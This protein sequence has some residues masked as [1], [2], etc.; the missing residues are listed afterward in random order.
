M[1]IPA[2]IEASTGNNL[3]LVETSGG[4]FLVDLSHC[5]CCTNFEGILKAP[6]KIPVLMSQPSLVTLCLPTCHG[7]Q[8]TMSPLCSKRC[9]ML[10]S[11]FF[12]ILFFINWRSCRHCLQSVHISNKNGFLRL[13]TGY[14][15]QFLE[16]NLTRR[17]SPCLLKFRFSKKATK[18]DLIFH[19]DVQ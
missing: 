6:I 2:N 9:A 16:E 12:G 4:N 14:E 19:F 8:Q 3:L 15:I 18:F 11:T 13:Q 5:L 1:V 17:V 10:L 7:F